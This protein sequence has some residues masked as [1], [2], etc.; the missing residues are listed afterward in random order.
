MRT[1][2]SVA[3]PHIFA[4]SRRSSNGLAPAP[5]INTQ[6]KLVNY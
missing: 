2:I 3:E 4:W 5:L 1:I 6:T